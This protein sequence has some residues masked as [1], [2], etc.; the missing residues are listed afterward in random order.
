[1]RDGPG[2]V[3]YVVSTWP[4][5]SQTFVVS[6][7]L[8]LE[9][10]GM[11]LEIFSVK[12]PEPEPV[13]DGVARVR[14]P[15]SYLTFH[16][17]WKAI[18]SA[19]LV[20][21][22]RQPRRYLRL[23]VL[24]LSYRS[25]GVLR[26]V[27]RAAYLADLLRDHGIVRQHAH[28]ATAPTLV[29]M[30]ASE[31]TGVPYSFTAHAR[32][33]YVDTRPALLRRQIERARVVV[34]ISEYN[35]RYLSDISAGANGK[36]RCIYNGLDLR[37]FTVGAA[38]PA[39]RG[40]P[41]VL[42]VGRLVE[43]KGLADLVGAVAVLRERG[44]AVSVE[45][46]GSGPLRGELE[47]LIVRS[48][49]SGTVRLLGAQAP[50]SVRAAYRRATVFALPCVVTAEGDRDGIPTVLLEAMASGVPVIS[51]PVSGVSELIDSRRNGILVEPGQPIALADALEELL[52]DAG[53][54][55][56]LARAGRITVEDRFSIDR[57][58]GELI[59]LFREGGA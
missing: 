51:T 37:E 18:L 52:E 58:A 9:R 56:R 31:M 24:A 57:S 28:F 49:L 32:D 36:V 50:Q 7:I 4:R 27:L 17:R 41:V 15:V 14:A 30:F 10:A 19:N 13:H 40:T 59:A 5:L 29:A 34:T 3:G 48:Q 43:K 11:R 8:A 44:R 1:M 45:I 46:I 33:I 25:V 39:G 12:R 21:L 47:S 35:R 22:R 6:E 42:T 16:G 53:L 2:I 55:K 20:Q 26:H 23:L 54:R 38:E